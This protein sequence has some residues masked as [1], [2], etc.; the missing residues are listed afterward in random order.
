MAAGLVPATADRV[1]GTT[2]NDQIV[3]LASHTLTGGT[4]SDTFVFNVNQG[5][6]IITDFNQTEHDRIDL[7]A[8]VATGNPNWISTHVAQSP[9]NPA[10]TLINIDTHDSILLQNVVASHLTAN[11][12]LLHPGGM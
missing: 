9:A 5:S 8:F 6:Y 7:S 2:G 11:D 4:G 12:F 3:A 1:N 10:D